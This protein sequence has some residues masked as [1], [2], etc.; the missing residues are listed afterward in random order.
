MLNRPAALKTLSALTLATLFSAAAQAAEP[1]FE[2]LATLHVKPA[3]LSAFE[4][5]LQGNAAAAKAQP[6]NLSFSVFESKADPTTVYVLE[7]WQ[8][9]AAYN[10]HLKSPK[11]LAMHALAKTA[12]QGGIEHMTLQG[13][14]PG[15]DVQPTK[16]DDQ[17]ATSDLFVFLTV[18][19]GSLDQFKANVSQV[20]PTFRKAD[21]NVAFDIFQDVDHPEQMVQLERWSNEDLHQ[22]NLKRPMIDTIRAGYKETLA[23]PMASGRV[24]LRDITQG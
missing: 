2:S 6:G 17:S 5:S 10:E 19:P 15:T 16:I 7:Q 14:G 18:K 11:L 22:A 20:I 24:L 23:K 21:G 4:A 3:S 13:V 8:N 9:K 1:T 12:L